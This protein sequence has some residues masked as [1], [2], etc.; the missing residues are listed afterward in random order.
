MYKNKLIE[1]KSQSIWKN[2]HYND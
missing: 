2:I 1:D